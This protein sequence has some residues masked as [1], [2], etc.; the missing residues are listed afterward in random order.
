MMMQSTNITSQ[1]MPYGSPGVNVDLRLFRPLNLESQ[2]CDSLLT[3]YLNTLPDKKIE[4][5]VDFR[6][7]HSESRVSSSDLRISQS[8]NCFI[9]SPRSTQK[10]CGRI[11][12][13]ANR[14]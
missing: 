5:H 8:A 3:P 14:P 1:N 9:L 11:D 13:A 10:R 4:G 2:I 12:G 7:Q 6:T